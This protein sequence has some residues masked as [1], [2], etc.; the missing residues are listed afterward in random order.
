MDLPEPN[1]EFGTRTPNFMTQ[2]FVNGDAKISI[3]MAVL[4]Q[5]FVIALGMGGTYAAVRGGIDAD[6]QRLDSQSQ[7]II[8]LQSTLASVQQTNIILSGRIDVLNQSITDLNTN[9]KT[10]QEYVWNNKSHSILRN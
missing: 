3:R 1:M 5:L 6:H 2:S 9:L 8:Q 10:I 4:I 7:T